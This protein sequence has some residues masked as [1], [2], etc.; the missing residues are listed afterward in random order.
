MQ[1]FGADGAALSSHARTDVSGV[2]PA[3]GG[4]LVTD[5]TGLVAALD[6]GGLRPLSSGPRAWDNH[7]VALA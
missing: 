5:G 7:L 1:V 3:P 6:P 4:F 2:A